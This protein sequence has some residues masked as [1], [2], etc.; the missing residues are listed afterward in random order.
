M[1]KK[2]NRYP[3]SRYPYP[4]RISGYLSGSTRFVSDPNPKMHYLG[5]TRIRPKYKNIRIRIRKNGYLY[6]P[7]PVHD[8]YTRTVFTPILNFRPELHHHIVL[9]VCLGWLQVPAPV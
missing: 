4:T 6:Y 3:D 8:E 1:Q 7:Y 2:K 5:I 9:R